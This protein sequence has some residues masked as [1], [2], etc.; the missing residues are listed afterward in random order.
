MLT[1]ALSNSRAIRLPIGVVP[2]GG[3]MAQL[4][5]IRMPSI[6]FV[7][8]RTYPKNVIGCENA[9]PWRLKSDLR[10][11]KRITVDH[12]IIMGSK[13]YYSIGKVLP[14]REN[15]VIS[16]K[17]HNIEEKDLF[18]CND[19]ETALLLADI[20]ALSQERKEIFIIGGQDMYKIFSG[21]FNKIHLTEIFDH[22]KIEGDAFFDFKFDRRKWRAIVEE[23]LGPSEDDEYPTRYT[24]Y[25]NKERK[26]RFRWSSNFLT[27]KQHVSGFI[28]KY[29]KEHPSTSPEI[30]AFMHQKDFYDFEL[31]D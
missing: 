27:D 23:D 12:S 25:E 7:V 17:S 21:V 22:G 15:I 28:D 11:F 3:A 29:K 24:V 30:E 9:L 31:A 14:R 13:T 8:A 16:R 6:S 18:W 10:R 4:K 26:N 20:F 1:F 5:K 2:K 19:K